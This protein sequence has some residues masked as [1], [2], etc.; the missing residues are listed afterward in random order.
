MTKLENSDCQCNHD[1][2][3]IQSQDAHIASEFEL[4]ITNSDKAFLAQLGNMGANTRITSRRVTNTTKRIGTGKKITLVKTS[5]V[6]TT[7]SGSSPRVEDLITNGDGHA[8]FGIDLIN[9]IPGNSDLFGWVNDLDSLIKD[10]NVGSNKEK[11]STDNSSA[12]DQRS[13]SNVAAVDG[14]LDNEAG[15]ENNQNAAA[16]KGAAGTE[17][18]DVVHE[19]SF[20]QME[21][22]N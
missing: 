18:L 7:W 2:R 10:Q 9:Q 20:S 22:I 15:E 5:L 8:V 4:G 13:H 14:A 11:V 19:H 12:A 17:F 6:S 1:E 3:N 16:Y 21:A